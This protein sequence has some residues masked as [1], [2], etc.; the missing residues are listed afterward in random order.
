MKRSTKRNVGSWPNMRDDTLRM[1]ADELVRA[2]KKHPSKGQ[3][4]T[5][6]L[7][8]AAELDLALKSNHHAKSADIPGVS[9][10]QIYALAATVAAMAI[11]I[12]EEG[13]A[14]Y[15]YGGNTQAPVFVLDFET[16]P[17]LKP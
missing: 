6:L 4:L 10:S 2:R 7:S 3:H 14:G 8:Y 9:A 1:I 12:M 11:R 5:F 17:W 16:N 13:S 15:V